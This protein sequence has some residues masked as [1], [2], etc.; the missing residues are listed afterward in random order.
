MSSHP[1]DLL[2]ADLLPA[3]P[4]E[5]MSAVVGLK[6]HA[7]LNFQALESDAQHWP[8]GACRTASR[9]LKAQK[10]GCPSAVA[11]AHMMPSALQWYPS[12]A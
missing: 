4:F 3:S 8:D 6:R 12:L 9:Y 10:Y 5:A 1:A 2:P 11:L 7:C